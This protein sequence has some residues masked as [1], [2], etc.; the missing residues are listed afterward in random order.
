M[1][2]EAKPIIARRPTNSSLSFVK[3][4]LNGNSMPFTF[5]GSTPIDFLKELPPA[6]LR[7]GAACAFDFRLTFTTRQ[8]AWGAMTIKLVA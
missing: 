1:S 8:A 6:A 3:P 7:A 5:G 4:I 2:E